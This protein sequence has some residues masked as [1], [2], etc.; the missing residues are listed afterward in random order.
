MKDLIRNVFRRFGYDI[1]KTGVPYVSKSKKP[2]TINVGKFRIEMPGNNIQRSNYIIFPDL[3]AQFGRL[4]SAICYKYSDMA[5]IDIGANVG[6][7]IAV[8]KS[9]VEIPIVGIEGDEISFKFLKKNIQQFLDVSIVKAFLG[10]KPETISANFSSVGWNT[11]ISPSEKGADQV[12]IRTL[13]DVI[14]SEIKKDLYYK[15]LKSDVEGFDTIVLRGATKIINRFKPVLFFEYNRTI[16][17]RNGEEG[18]STI[19]SFRDFGYDK[20]VFF[21]HVGTLLLSTSLA[22]KEVITH[23]HEYISSDK[24]LLGYFDI[25]IFHESDTDIS[26]QYVEEER[27][28]L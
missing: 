15:L 11:T 20:I 7:T 8:L 12:S 26:E 4:A 27:K 23:L 22:N 2:V 10:D 18:L 9:F 3:N 19:F 17:K 1:I 6:D 16:M 21:D 5:A 25:A 13:D 14:S 24:N 28:Y